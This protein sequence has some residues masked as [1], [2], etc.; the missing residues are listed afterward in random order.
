MADHAAASY[1]LLMN[2]FVI[3]SLFATIEWFIGLAFLI[4]S[5]FVAAPVSFG[6][7][8]LGFVFM[9]A[10]TVQVVRLQ[11]AVL[12]RAVLTPQGITTRAGRSEWLSAR[13]KELFAEKKDE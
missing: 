6:V 13:V 1:I 9:S 8:A 11:L 7:A 4:A 5:C 3:T 10:A 2:K 12:L